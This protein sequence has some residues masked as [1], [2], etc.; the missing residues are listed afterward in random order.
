MTAREQPPD[1]R[2]YVHRTATIADSARIDPSAWIG[3]RVRIGANS[4]IGPNCVIGGLGFGYSF[5]NGGSVPSC[6]VTWY[7][8]G[9]SRWRSSS[10][11]GFSYNIGRLVRRPG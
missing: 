7:C 10:S 2:P 11:L 9:E 6:W 5:R 8:I 3:P 1:G 4:S